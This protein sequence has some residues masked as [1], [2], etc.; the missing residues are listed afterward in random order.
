MVKKKVCTGI[1]THRFGH[2]SLNDGLQYLDGRLQTFLLILL[3]PSGVN[4]IHIWTLSLL[5]QKPVSH[6]LDLIAGV[7]P[8]HDLEQRLA[9]PEQRFAFRGGFHLWGGVEVLVE[10]FEADTLEDTCSV[11]SLPRETT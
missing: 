8:G 2:L 11:V 9:F 3:R 7:L 4:C 1:I 10:L 5:P 6:P